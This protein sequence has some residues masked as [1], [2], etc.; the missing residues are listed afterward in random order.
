[1]SKLNVNKCQIMN[2]IEQFIQIVFFLYIFIGELIK[3]I[4]FDD[5]CLYSFWLRRIFVSGLLQSCRMMQ[6]SCCMQFLYELKQLKTKFTNSIRF[7][8]FFCA[9]NSWPKIMQDEP[10]QTIQV[11]RVPWKSVCTWSIRRLDSLQSL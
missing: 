4:E 9:Q 2:H 7:S 5:T 11:I 1:M 10:N 6:E 8:G 3:R